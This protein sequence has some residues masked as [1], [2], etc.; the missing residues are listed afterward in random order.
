MEWNSDLGYD[1]VN[2]ENMLSAISQTRRANTAP[3]H[4]HEVNRTG[5][6]LEN[7]L[8]KL[9]GLVG[10]GKGDGDERVLEQWWL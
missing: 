8:E 1:R 9:Q 5:A 3:F 4:L 7:R 6:S 10:G 2:L